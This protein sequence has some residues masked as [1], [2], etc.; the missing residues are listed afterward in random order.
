MKKE[1]IGCK[2]IKEENFPFRFINDNIYIDM[3][4][5]GIDENGNQID[6]F[7][8]KYCPFCGKKLDIK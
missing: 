7:L 8:I 2:N 1:C 3:E 5:C 4:G 6:Y